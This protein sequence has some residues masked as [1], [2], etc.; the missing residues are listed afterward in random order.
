MRANK[1]ANATTKEMNIMI[2][3]VGGQGIVTMSELLGSAAVDDGQTV[4]GSEILGMAQR[5]GRVVS[6]VRIG[7]HAIAPLI[8]ETGCDVMLAIEPSEVLH[9]L[10][11]LNRDS[12]VV[13]NTSEVI[14]YTV[15]LGESKYP[16]LETI[17]QRLNATGLRVITIDATRIAS[18]AGSKRITNLVMLG[19]LFGSGRV[20]IRIETIK[21]VIG[22]R[23][24]TRLAQIHCAAFDRGYDLVKSALQC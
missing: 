5:G 18:D 2:C 13:L 15:I 24:G 4:K 6:T 7:G 23:F 14:P 19:A 9:Y 1:M 17:L 10:G 20:P 12:L 11:Y 8:P 22:E 3:G 21:S 16:D